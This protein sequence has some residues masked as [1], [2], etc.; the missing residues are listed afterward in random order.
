M[1]FEQKKAVG[2]PKAITRY[3]IFS[4]I[5]MVLVLLNIFYHGTVKSNEPKTEETI[6]VD[7]KPKPKNSECN[8]MIAHYSMNI[9]MVIAGWMLMTAIG[10]IASN[11]SRGPAVVKDWVFYVPI[12]VGVWNILYAMFGNWLAE[13]HGNDSVW[14]VNN[15]VVNMTGVGLLVYYR[16]KFRTGLHF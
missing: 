2:I 10:Y 13:V 12:F 1:N 4:G 14:I 11:A 6:D 9:S 16:N 5:I 15:T 3:M 7:E 8:L